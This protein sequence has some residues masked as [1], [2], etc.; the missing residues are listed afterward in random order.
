MQYKIDDQI[1]K[2]VREY[3]D[4]HSNKRGRP[5]KFVTNKMP[6]QYKM[7]LVRFTDKDGTKMSGLMEFQHW[8]DG[9]WDVTEIYA[10]ARQDED[11]MVQGFVNSEEYL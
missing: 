4:W 7:L 2:A 10:V 1:K 8:N 3:Y 9:H 5:V 11:W 6:G